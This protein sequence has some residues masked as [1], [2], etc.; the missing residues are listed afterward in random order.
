[1]VPVRTRMPCASKDRARPW[2]TAWSALASKVGPASKIVTL[3][4][5]SDRMEAIW[6]PVSAPPTIATP[7]GRLVRDGMSL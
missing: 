7:D 4:P 6:Q 1:M 2:L 5:K 3:T